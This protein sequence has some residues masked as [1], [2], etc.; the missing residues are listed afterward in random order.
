MC[1][2]KMSVEKVLRNEWWDATANALSR[3]YVSIL[4]DLSLPNH[5]Y[6]NGYRIES[7]RIRLYALLFHQ[8]IWLMCK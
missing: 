5:Y 2:E 3:H 7:I 6:T 1:V 4:P 8:T